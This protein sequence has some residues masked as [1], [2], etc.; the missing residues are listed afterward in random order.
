MFDRRLSVQ[1]IASST[2]ILIPIIFE[3]I[4]NDFLASMS[5]ATNPVSGDEVNSNFEEFNEM[6]KRTYFRFDSHKDECSG[7]I[8]SGQ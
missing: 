5:V 4:Q 7:P 1:A 2:S 6:I 3:A 8:P